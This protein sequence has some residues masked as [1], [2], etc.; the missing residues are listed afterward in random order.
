MTGQF[1]NFDSAF[2]AWYKASTAY[3]NNP[4]NASQKQAAEQT[5]SAL[6]DVLDKAGEAADK[7]SQDR[8]RKADG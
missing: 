1:R 3:I 5:F 4:A 2:D 7:T 6:R 8:N